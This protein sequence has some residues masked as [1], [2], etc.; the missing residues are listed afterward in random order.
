M[1]NPFFRKFG[2]KEKGDQEGVSLGNPMKNAFQGALHNRLL[3]RPAGAGGEGPWWA[4]ERHGAG[5]R[6]QQQFREGRGVRGAAPTSEW[7]FVGED[8]QLSRGVP[9]GPWA[10]GLTSRV[11][12][13]HPQGKGLP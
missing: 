1:V 13:T 4:S 11:R 12:W 7:E 6:I 3:H 10:L 9:C 8:K 5:G 2:G